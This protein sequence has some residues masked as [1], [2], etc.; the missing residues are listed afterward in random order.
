MFQ[1]FLISSNGMSERVRVAVEAERAVA[2]KRAANPDE[3]ERLEGEAEWLARARHPG[4]VELVA[5]A[6]HGDDA[7]LRTGYAGRPLSGL[8]AID[9]DHAAGIVAAV[10]ETVA[11]LHDLGIVHGRLGPS[12]VLIGSGG[13]PRV[14]GLSGA[15][16]VADGARTSDDVAALGR[17]LADL[18]GSDAAVE[19][20]PD[21]RLRWRRR[22][23]WSDHHR[24]ALLTLADQASADEPT[25]RPAARA[26]AAAIQ[27]A[28]PSAVL[29]LANE[30]AADADELRLADQ[31]DQLPA[32]RRD[33]ARLGTRGVLGILGGV[34]VAG[35][36]AAMT[37]RGPAAATDAAAPTAPV[38]MHATD[39]TDTTHTTTTRTP[40][41]ASR[42]C[43]SQRGATADVTGDGCADVVVINGPMI[44]F[45]DARFIVGEAGDIATV[46]DWDC[47][48]VATPALLRRASGEVFIFPTWAERGRDVTVR[49]VARR[50]G[51]RRLVVRHLSGGCD[52]LS[53]D[54]LRDRDVWPPAEHAQA[55]P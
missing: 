14:C 28:V 24:R 54:S 43:T 53:V 17:M 7:E 35:G 50:A 11:D 16:A 4:V 26:L 38:A 20:I 5:F 51:A 15:G 27:A 3:I 2:I 31:L 47:D 25:R 23:R 42:R 9:V 46:G 32:P 48:G 12:H 30:P 19:P 39:T 52:G 34:L 18:I 37:A 21:R 41:A 8:P 1:C 33:S 22:A 49:A 36:L 40:A 13:R 29:R 6:R 10:S 55:R 45:G 44:E